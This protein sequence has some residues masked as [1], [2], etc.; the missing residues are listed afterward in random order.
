MSPLAHYVVETLVTLLAIVALAVVVLIGARRAGMGRAAGPLEMVG[1]LP[2][3]A[4]RAVYLVR[5]G[6]VVYVLGA[7]EA[8]IAK[9]GEVAEGSIDLSSAAGPS[10]S[11]REVLSRALG[12]KA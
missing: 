9:L 3:D 10:E 5:V 1:R 8:G 7:S 2:L 12:K 11:F 6:S 4:R